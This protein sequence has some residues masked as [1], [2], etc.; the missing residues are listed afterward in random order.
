MEVIMDVLEMEAEFE[1]K[2]LHDEIQ[3]LTNEIT[4]LR[5]LLKDAGVESDISDISDEEA[6][7]VEQI[8]MLKKTS[9]ER[10]LDK[11]EVE[12]LD[13][14]HKNLKIARGEVGKRGQKKSKIGKMS[15]KELEALMR[16]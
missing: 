1:K 2:K 12:K 10:E 13:I 3:R 11:K 6:I 15:D 14:L 9:A 7:C 8:R 16:R 4:K 5:I